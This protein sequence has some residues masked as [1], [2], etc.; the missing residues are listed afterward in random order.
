MKIKPTMLRFLG[1]ILFVSL[2][3]AGCDRTRAATAAT[4]ASQT[5]AAK[6]DTPKVAK[7]VFVGK[8]HACDCT[9]KTL[10]GTWAV[11]EKAL[12]TP[13]KLPVE[14][15][16]IDTQADQVTPYKQQKPIMALPAIYFLD[17]KGAL[18]DFLQ[19]EV[20]SDQVLAAIK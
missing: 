5:V 19:G 14:R 12:G 16:Q 1:T 6:P 15:L 7:I 18:V 17:N 9:R 4:S 20:T 13:A 10:D 3:I 11:L 2:A 8:E